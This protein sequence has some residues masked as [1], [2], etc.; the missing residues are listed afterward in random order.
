MD[1]M[2]D[3]DFEAEARAAKVELIST[4]LRS[5]HSTLKENG[6]L[7][8]FSEVG[9]WVKHPSFPFDALVKASGAKPA[10]ETT[11]ALT[12]QK[13]SGEGEG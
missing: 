3:R 9:V 6:C 11:R 5:V 4:H 2:T 1:A 12:L 10:S 8:R 7:G 13:L